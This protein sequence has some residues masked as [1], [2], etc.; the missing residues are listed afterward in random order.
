MTIAYRLSQRGQIKAIKLFLIGSSFFFYGYYE[1]SLVPLLLTSI[2]INYFFSILITAEPRRGKLLLAL[3]ITFNLSLLSYYK[4]YNFFTQ[5]ILNATVFSIP[6]KSIVLPLAISFFTFQQLAYL[7]DLYRRQTERADFFDYALFVSFFPQLIAGPIV[8]YKDI[9]AQ[10]G[11]R[12]DKLNADAVASGLYLF[13]IG[14]FKKVL[15]ADS[16]AVWA[17]NG[18]DSP[19]GLNCLGAWLSTLG[20]TFQIYFDFSGYMDMALG[21][22]KMLNI[23]L[24]RNFNSP[25]KALSI[26]D[27]WRRWHITLG[28]F[29]KNYLYIPIGGNQKGLLRTM[30]NGIIVF[31]LGGLW[32]GASW[33]FVF[34][35][36]IHG[37]GLAINTLWSRI[38]IKFPKPFAWGMTFLFVVLAWVPFRAEDMNT[39]LQVYSKLFSFA[40]F[41][42]AMSPNKIIPYIESGVTP[43]QLSYKIPFI[44]LLSLLSI[45]LPKNSYD[46]FQNFKPTW[47]NNVLCVALMCGS[48]LF[49]SEYT[50]FI[51]F[52]F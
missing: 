14:L 24:P 38:G 4:Y 5:E 44:L 21:A 47:S 9:A 23:D 20:Y 46:Q 7:V 45:A 11:N 1:W 49:F 3:G 36:L 17:S 12:F 15:I 50:E 16:L 10:Y 43:L 33:T 29:L 35:G 6:S 34:W 32:H 25:Y 40:E 19:S 27:F 41:A 13:S 31:T 2:A 28:R 39:A 37:V 51:Y 52:N 26:Q 30:L 22:A 18:F 42:N 8:L 48:M